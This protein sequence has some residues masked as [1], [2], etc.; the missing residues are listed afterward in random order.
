MKISKEVQ[1]AIVLGGIS[2]SGL[3]QAAGDAARLEYAKMQLTRAGK[4]AE[5]KENE[6]LGHPEAFRVHAADGKSVIEAGSAAG[7]LYGVQALLSGEYENGRVEKPDFAIRGTTLC[8]MSGN[9]K[10]TISPQ[11]YPWFYDK[12]FMIRTL[13]AFAR[14]RLNTIF[15]WAGHMFPYIVEMPDYPEAAA[16][17]PPEQVKANQEQ[18]RWFTT[19]CEKRNIQVLLHFYNIHVS[20]PFAEKH[21]MPTNPKKPTPLLKEYTHYALTRY[22]EEFAA[23]GLYACPGESIESG[24][25]LEWFRDVIFDAAKKSGKNPTI[26]IRD[27]TVNMDFRNQIRS[28]YDEVYTELK[29][30]DESFC[31]PYPDVRHMQLEGIAKGHIV[32]FH[33]VT[34]LVPMR[35]GSPVLLQETMGHLKKLGFVHGVE[36][37]GQS[38]WKWPY[39]LDKLT[40]EQQGYLPQGPK[41]YS[42]DRDAIY[43]AAFGRYLWRSEREPAG[44]ESY[45]GGYLGRKFGAEAA[46]K[47]LYQW[48]I[49][50]GPIGPG[51][52]NITATKVAGFWPSVML[53]NQSVDEILTL[54]K[55]LDETPYTLYRETGR[56]QQ[57]FYPRPFD[58]YFFARYRQQFGVPKPGKLPVM[59]KEM[60]AYKQRLESED[61]EQ[62][63]CMP[64]TQYAGF[65]VEDRS[66]EEALT[67]DNVA[68]LLNILAKESLQLAREAQSAVTDPESQKELARFVTDSEMYV[69]ATQAMIHKVNAAILKARI[70]RAGAK[71]E[72][73]QFLEEMEASVAV[74]RKLADLTATTYLHGNDLMGTHWKDKTVTEFADDLK[75]QREWL[76]KWLA[77]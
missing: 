54:N 38:F 65:L 56:A 35:W 6:N 32:N 33:L 7:A 76:A 31:S 52:Q 21:G 41:L 13:D 46:G 44:E 36:F 22:F 72:A 45:W 8:M 61:L 24:S 25:Q 60:D 30:N 71:D 1:L 77:K 62:R 66:V 17:V 42:V 63:H 10:A 47:L 37:Y 4:Q 39:T 12:P 68:T 57:R 53:Q 27:W 70:L 15:L 28:L 14:A 9:Y 18:F 34:D 3:C 73:A 75:K 74:C 50:T 51:L 5:L 58:T 26:A 29:H 19:E 69:L 20:P 2:S 23:V 49:V 11:D 16:D 59:Y 48:Y 43:F 67:P 40:P 64:V 55:S